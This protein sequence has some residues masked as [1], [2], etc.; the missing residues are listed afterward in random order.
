MSTET[1]LFSLRFDRDVDESRAA[2]LMV[3]HSL[4]QE[5]CSAPF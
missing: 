5:L 4:L 3:T 2:L 1:E